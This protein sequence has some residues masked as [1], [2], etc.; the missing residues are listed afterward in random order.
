M[1]IIVTLLL[2]IVVALGSAPAVDAAA[3]AEEPYWVASFDKGG[4]YA[5]P[6]C[7]LMGRMKEISSPLWLSFR[8]GRGGF[9]MV[10]GGMFKAKPGSVPVT[11]KV[12]GDAKRWLFN[13]HAELN[14]T[15]VPMPDDAETRALFERLRHARTID[16]N[17]N[18]NDYALGLNGWATAYPQWDSCYQSLLR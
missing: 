13:G 12:D 5:L 11:I 9:Q 1:R 3:Y 17:A 2:W 7:V 15:T 6:A 16:L 4:S 18:N 10:L 8:S 14:S